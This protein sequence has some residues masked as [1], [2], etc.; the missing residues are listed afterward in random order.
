[1]PTGPQLRASC[2]FR[3]ASG[4]SSSVRLRCINVGM[5]FE[6]PC[7]TPGKRRTYV[8][9]TVATIV[10]FCAISISS[11]LAQST[12]SGCGVS[13]TTHQV[14]GHAG[15]LLR[16]IEHA[17]RNAI[18]PENL[19]W[20]LP[21][22]AATGLL[23]AEADQSAANRIQSPSL[24]HTARRWSN[25]GLGTEIIA[26]GATWG[27]GCLAHKHSLIDNGITA[28]TA[29]GAA[30]TLDLALKLSFDREFPYKP[31]SRGAFWG[32][33]RSF[34]SGHAATS[35][36]F[37]SAIAHRYPHNQWIRL[38]AYG[39]ATGVAL[40]RYP[41]KRHYLSDILVGS[42]LGYVSGTYVAQH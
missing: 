31:G 13:A 24:I 40:S 37:A 6:A 21:I 25:I 12:E 26:A 35:F 14:L 32:G 38:G 20:E 17:P 23:I 10:L 15:Q 42:A 28:L 33:G 19:K 18:R 1:M 30:S 39:M 34:P 2:S 29:M 16:G 4:S 36:A 27:G 8:S 41:A 7:D 11:G 3:S 22:G 9:S 5:H